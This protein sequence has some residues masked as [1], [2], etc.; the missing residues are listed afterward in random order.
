MPDLE[1]QLDAYGDLLDELAWD[2]TTI[3][4]P[5]RI[6]SA[7]RT[8]SSRTKLVVA[9]ALV[10]AI[11]GSLFVAIRFT[12]D[13]GE[14]TTTGAA[15]AFTDLPCLVRL[16]AAPATLCVTDYDPNHVAYLLAGFEPGTR[17]EA[18]TLDGSTSQSSKISPNGTNTIRRPLQRTDP[19]KRMGASFSAA[20]PLFANGAR[21]S[22]T[23]RNHR[24]VT[25]FVP[26]PSG[27][28][29]VPRTTTRTEHGPTTVT[30]VDDTRIQVG[31]ICNRYG[32]A[33]QTKRTRRTVRVGVFYSDPDPGEPVLDCLTLLEVALP[34]PIGARTLV[35]ATTGQPLRVQSDARCT[36][37][38]LDKD[39][40]SP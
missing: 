15:A 32:P 20:A 17:Y 27:D 6:T 10:V 11:V 40:T 36:P 3:D 31:A 34:E 33:V 25:F 38:S 9:F 26:P 2:T 5:A 29:T 24:S 19:I 7:R 12:D 16:T 35:A 28:E 23:T 4:E 1:Q 14:P 18:S 30:I 21:I 13:D 22:G 39:C 8:G 37:P